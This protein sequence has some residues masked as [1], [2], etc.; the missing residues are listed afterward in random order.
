M[1]AGRH[2]LDSRHLLDGSA[3]RYVSKH[4]LQCCFPLVLTLSE[5]Q[6]QSPSQSRIFFEACGPLQKRVEKKIPKAEK[7]YT[8]RTDTETESEIWMYR[9]LF[10][11]T[12]AVHV[13]IDAP[14]Y[15]WYSFKRELPRNAFQFGYCRQIIMIHIQYQSNQSNKSLLF[16]KIQSI[17]MKMFL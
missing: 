11:L 3:R 13:A 10:A 9:C 17:K 6:N 5:Y 15:V 7:S 1:C 14:C 16:I 4:V 12:T 8:V 2:L